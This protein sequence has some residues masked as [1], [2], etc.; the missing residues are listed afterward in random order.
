MPNN[1]QL[2]PQASTSCG[3]NND[4]NVLIRFFENLQKR[5]DQLGLKENKIQLLAAIFMFHCQTLT[6]TTR[7]S[8]K[9]LKWRRFSLKK[10]KIHGSAHSKKNLTPF[11]VSISEE[12]TMLLQ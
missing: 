2:L 9:H 5:P 10:H 7:G 12:I 8:W 3:D 6:L 1:I 11:F 4:S